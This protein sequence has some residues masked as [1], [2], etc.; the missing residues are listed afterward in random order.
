VLKNRSK[1]ILVGFILTVLLITWVAYGTVVGPDGLSDADYSNATLGNFE[2]LYI[3]DENYTAS[4]VYGIGTNGIDNANSSGFIAHGLTGIPTG[5][6]LTVLNA[7][8]D[9]VLTLV[10]WDWADSNTT[11]LGV[12]LY[13]V[14]GTVIPDPLTISW[15]ATYEP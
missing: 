14:N 6:Q 5:A 1:E 2:S 4:V 12:D 9:S 13:W 7:T 8:Y 11:H 3:D 10:Y 15:S